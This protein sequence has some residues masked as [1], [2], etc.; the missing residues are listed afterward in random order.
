[1]SNRRIAVVGAGA[2]GA[3]IVAD[4]VRAGLDVPFIEPWPAH[5]EKMRTTGMRVVRSDESFEKL[6]E[7]AARLERHELAASPANADRLRALLRT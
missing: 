7:I 2:N 1:M 4:F 3:G 5:V 6:V